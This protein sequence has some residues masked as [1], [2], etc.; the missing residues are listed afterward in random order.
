[1]STNNQTA[2]A[3]LGDLERAGFWGSLEIKFEGGSVVLIKK[4]E[5]LKPNQRSNRGNENGTK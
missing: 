4:T 3:L 5:T 1:V 2:T